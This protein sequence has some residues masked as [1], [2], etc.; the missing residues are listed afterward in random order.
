MS[1]GVADGV[2]GGVAACVSLAWNLTRVAGDKFEM[3]GLAPFFSTLSGLTFAA[4][5][6]IGF[7]FRVGAM[8]T[9]CDHVKFVFCASRLSVYM[10]ISR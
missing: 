7:L 9:L 6:G 3:M 4:F 5:L 8:L 10:L 2:V 1:G